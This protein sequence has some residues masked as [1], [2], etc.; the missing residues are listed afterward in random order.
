MHEYDLI[1]DWYAADRKT[2]I[3]VP[4][5]TAFAIFRSASRAIDTC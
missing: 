2:D 4:E 1:A 5:V 3:G